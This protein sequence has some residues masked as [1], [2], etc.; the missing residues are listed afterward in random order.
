MGA[1]EQIKTRTEQIKAQIK[2]S[3]SDW[4]KEKFQ[5]RLARL[6]G[7]VAIIK[8]GAPTE[9]EMK[10]RKRRVEGSLSATRAAREE[11]ILPGG[12]V[13]L[14]NALSALDKIKADDDIMT[15]VNII[16]RAL[17]EPIRQLVV[18]A[19]V[20]GAVV[21]EKIK[22]SPAGIGFDVVTEQYVNMFEKG[23][24]DPVKV[25]RS[26]L[27]NAAS[28]ATLALITE[29]LMTDIPEKEKSQP[30]MPME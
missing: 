27:Q 19:G 29:A 28:V 26:A 3:T 10:D 24:I 20:E 12:G 17:E 9:V 5:E 7:G 21:I 22:N 4:D 14:L 25:T 1:P 15:G 11:G 16:R 8:V 2:E 30:P 13:G 23:I 18:N 6:S